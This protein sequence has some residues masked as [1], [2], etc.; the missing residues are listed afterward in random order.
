VPSFQFYYGATVAGVGSWTNVPNDYLTQYLD[1]M[2]YDINLGYKTNYCWV[3]G[4]DSTNQFTTDNSVVSDIPRYMGF[5]KCLYM[6]G[7][8]GAIQC[9]FS[10]PSVG[11][12]WP[13]NGFDASFPSN[14]PPNWLQQ[15]MALSQV[16]ALFSRL[17]NF[18]DNS[19]LI[20][21]P[22]CHVLSNDQPAY[23]FTNT[24]ADT[25][26]R[27]LAR[28]LRTDNQW[29]ITAW[30]ASGTNRNVTVNIPALGPVTVLA[31]D[32]GA[33]YQ[34]TTTNTTLIDLDGMHPTAQLFPCYSAAQT[35]PPTNVSVGPGGTN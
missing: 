22:Q 12:K 13:T 31:R 1:Q 11:V 2:G 16:H 33:V 8:N 14:S 30:A 29:L 15:M 5:L 10:V 24:V 20:S 25:M 9:C 27:V 6:G 18:T 4:G 35:S 7:M 17:E 34:V 23:E 3:D 28:K 21:G 32:S 26:A 19:D